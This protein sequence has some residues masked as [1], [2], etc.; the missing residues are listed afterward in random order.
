MEGSRPLLV[1][2]ATFSGWLLWEVPEILRRASTLQKL[3]GQLKQVV[4]LLPWYGKVVAVEGDRVYVNVGKE[5]ELRMGQLLKV[6]RGGKVVKGLGFAPGNKVGTIEVS[7]FVG[8]NGAYGIIREGSGM[9]VSDLVAF[10]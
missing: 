1:A 9:R 6:Y 4:A 2:S 8:A 7:G 10:E 3:S 5:A